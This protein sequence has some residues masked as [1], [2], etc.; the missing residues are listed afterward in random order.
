MVLYWQDNSNVKHQSYLN[1][2][3]NFNFETGQTLGT[4]WTNQEIRLDA[5][6]TMSHPSITYNGS[7]IIAS[8]C[9]VYYILYKT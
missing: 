6:D 5:D 2:T 9:V 3:A 1:F 4:G 8:S 7:S